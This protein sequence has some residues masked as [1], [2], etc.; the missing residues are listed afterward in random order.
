MV[1]QRVLEIFL[2]SSNLLIC[3][4][5]VN[6]CLSY[7]D[8][9]PDGFYMIHGMDPYVWA[10][11][12]DHQESGR[13]PSLESL[14]TVDIAIVSAVEVILV[15]RRYDPSLIELQN[16]IH[17]LSSSCITTKEI[18]DQLAKLVCNHMG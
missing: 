1:F 14:R 5:Q 15:D 10:M 11:C 8:K 17:N 2:I 4:H 3:L 6:G 18:V 7:F 16:R 12:S 13:I 9:V